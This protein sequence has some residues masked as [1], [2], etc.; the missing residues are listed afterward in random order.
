MRSAIEPSIYRMIF[1]FSIWGCLRSLKFIIYDYE[2]S[3]DTVGRVRKEENLHPTTSGTFHLEQASWIWLMNTLLQQ[4]PSSF[5]SWVFIFNI[6][7]RNSAMFPSMIDQEEKREPMHLTSFSLL[8]KHLP[9]YHYTVSWYAHSVA[10][11]G[12]IKDRP[13]SMDQ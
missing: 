6:K 3:T 8:H 13:R 11:L 10:H 2:Y 12:S 7:P 9:V 1:T 5:Q 4:T